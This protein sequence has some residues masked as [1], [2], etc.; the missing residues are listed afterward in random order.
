MVLHARLTV[1]AALVVAG[2]A[3]AAELAGHSV[4]AIAS[5]ASCTLVFDGG[6]VALDL[7]APC[8]LH[9]ADGAV[10][11]RTVDGEVRFLVEASRPAGSDCVTLVRG[12]ALRGGRAVPSEH[13]ATVAACPPMLWDEVMFIGLFD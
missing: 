1:A 11:T 9:K 3:A 5:G 6:S 8:A 7:P 2:P 12:V 4:G 10:R 13:V